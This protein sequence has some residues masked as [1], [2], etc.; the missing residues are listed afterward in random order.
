MLLINRHVVPNEEKHSLADAIQYR[1]QHSQTDDDFA[2][3][4]VWYYVSN[5][6]E[7]QVNIDCFTSDD[8]FTDDNLF[9]ELRPDIGYNYFDF[10]TGQQMDEQGN[11]YVPPESPA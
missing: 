1:S 3:L 9:T 6:E 7:K 11:P 10:S 5:G 8:E 2:H 4:S